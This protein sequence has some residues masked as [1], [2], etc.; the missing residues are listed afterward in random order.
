MSIDP[1]VGNADPSA[2]HRR[3]QC[4]TPPRNDDERYPSGAPEGH[5]GDFGAVAS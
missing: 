1:A 5:V 3:A 4:R 2:H